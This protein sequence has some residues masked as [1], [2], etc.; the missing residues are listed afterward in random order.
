MGGDACVA[1]VGSV[2]PPIPGK[3]S[4]GNPGNSYETRMH[5]R[6]TCPYF[7]TKLRHEGLWL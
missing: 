1:P 4:F 2:I 5:D 3:I 6:N 7:S